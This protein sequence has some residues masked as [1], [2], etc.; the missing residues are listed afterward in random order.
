M[1][2]C[3]LGTLNENN[4]DGISALVGSTWEGLNSQ[5]AVHQGL[6]ITPLDSGALSVSFIHSKEIPSKPFPFISAFIQAIS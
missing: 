4:A 6:E 1:K 3:A 5:E 2:A